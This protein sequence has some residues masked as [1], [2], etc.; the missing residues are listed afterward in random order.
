MSD[1]G[2]ERRGCIS[3]SLALELDFAVHRLIVR[4]DLFL[5][6][7]PPNSPSFSHTIIHIARC[8]QP[9]SQWQPA[10]SSNLPTHSHTI[11]LLPTPSPNPSPTPSQPIP[12]IPSPSQ[13]IAKHSHPILGQIQGQ[14]HTLASSRSHTHP[15]TTRTTPKQPDLQATTSARPKPHK[16]WRC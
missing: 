4:S 12:Q 16:S 10:F 11:T 5:L 2:L 7:I 13:K 3:C 15:E 8:I 1:D 9:S 6:L 14:A